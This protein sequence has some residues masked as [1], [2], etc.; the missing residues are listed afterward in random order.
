MPITT[1]PLAANLGAEI[2]GLDVRGPSENDKAR[3]RELFDEHHL[4]L[5][6]NVNLS[7]DRHLELTQAIG[8]ISS[9]DAIMKDGRKFT[10]ISNIH[11]DGRLPTGELLFHADHMFLEV[12][13]KAISLYALAVP[14]RGGETRFIDASRAY[15]ELPQELQ[16]GIAHLEARHVYDYGAN[17]GNQAPKLE[18]LSEQ[19]DTAVHPI[20]WPHPETGEPILFVSRLFTVEVIGIPRQE[21]DALLQLLFSH[22]DS[23]GSDYSHRWSVGDLMIWDNRIL[24]HARNDF[25]PKEKRALR[26]VPIGEEASPRR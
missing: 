12:P 9:A 2:H 10:H 20:V 13:L 17:R 3:I 8:P 18:E 7:E 1:R 25:D 23:R 22:L 4:L 26:R 11:A 16:D 15:R 24:Q 21:G 14:S 19:T 6:R 5:F